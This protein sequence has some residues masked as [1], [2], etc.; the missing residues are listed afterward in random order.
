MRREAFALC[1][2]S[3][4]ERKNEFEQRR[5]G[6]KR[7]KRKKKE[8]EEEAD[9]RMNAILLLSAERPQVLFA[10]PACSAPLLLLVPPPPPSSTLANSSLTRLWNKLAVLGLFQRTVEKEGF[11]KSEG[12][13]EEWRGG[14]GRGVEEMGWHGWDGLL[15]K[16]QGY[17]VP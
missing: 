8:E 4:R 6:K 3:F 11:R 13:Q 12:S 5:T 16:K 15:I 1:I 14:L 7:R 17:F 10:A 9:S 2:R